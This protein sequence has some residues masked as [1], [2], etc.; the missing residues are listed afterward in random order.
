MNEA[1]FMQNGWHKVREL[2]SEKRDPVDGTSFEIVNNNGSFQ[3][4]VWFRGDA[5]VR[6]G[7]SWRTLHE[8]KRDAWTYYQSRLQEAALRANPLPP[9]RNDL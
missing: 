3:W 6:Y 2:N 9:A 1:E 8:A 5:I 7:S 4:I